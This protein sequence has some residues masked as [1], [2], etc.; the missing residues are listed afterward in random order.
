LGLIPLGGY[1]KIAGMV[2]E[3]MDTEFLEEE[4][5]PW[6]FRAKPVWQRMI[7]ISAGVLFNFLFAILVFIGLK[8]V[9]GEEYIP[10]DRISHVYVEKG[11]IAWKMG[12]RTGDRIVAVNGKPLEAWEDLFE[13]AVLGSDELVLTVERNGQL[14]ELRAPPD[15]L[16]RLH[17]EGRLG[18]YIDPA[19]LVVEV[20]PDSPADSAGLQARDI[21]LAVNDSTVYFPSEFSRLVNAAGGAPV[22]VTWERKDTSEARRKYEAWIK[23][24]LKKDRYV[25]GVSIATIER[26]PETIGVAYRSYSLPEAVVA[27]TREAFRTTYAILQNLKKIVTGRESLK[28][29]LG[30][31][32][33]VAQITA[34][35]AEQGARQ[36]WFIVAMLSITLAIVNI[37]P[38]PVLD[39]GHLVF[40]LYEAITGREPS[41]KVRMVAQQIGMALILLLFVFLIYNDIRRL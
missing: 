35:A 22:K 17:R 19:L 34:Q 38:I 28:D 26:A 2:D 37:L 10:A 40:L 21:I 6:E 41:P 3:S 29:N 7:V 31:P 11:S 36:F 27:G 33:A 18:V 13:L 32:I 5:K 20:L 9:Y 24:V 8:Y 39:G 16:S 23:P 1:V 15:L 12:L 4:P 25:I 14:I 30:G